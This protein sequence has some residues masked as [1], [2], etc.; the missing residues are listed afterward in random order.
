LSQAYKSPE[1]KIKRAF[2]K[3]GDLG[4]VAEE[5]TVP[6]TGRLTIAQVFHY[7]EGIAHTSGKGS[8]Q[9]KVDC[10]VQLLSKVS[11]AEAKY[12]VRT[13]LGTHRIG[14]GDMTFLRALAKAFTGKKHDKEVLESA[15]NVLSDLG[16]V[17][18]RLADKGI[19][20]LARVKPSP[21]I[22]VRMMLASRVKGL[23][24][25]PLHFKDG[26]F[27]EY[28]YDGERLQVHKDRQGRVHAFSRRLENITHQYPEI[29]EQASATLKATE[30]IVEGEA[31]CVDPKTGKLRPFQVLMQRKRKH[32]IERYRSQTPA[33]LFL[34]DMLYLDG[35][36][37]LRLPL[38]KRKKLLTDHLTASRGFTVG[39]FI[40]TA[41]MA[42]VESYFREAI[43]KGAEG[44]V[45]KDS[46]GPYQA[47]HR[48]WYWIKFK[49]EY[50]RELADTFDVVI[51]GALYGRGRRAGSYGS[52]LVASFDPKTNKYYSF[53]KVGAGFTDAVLRSLP[54][55]L[56]PCIIPE[57]DHLVVTEMPA[58]VWFEP[59]RVIEISGADLT[60][61]PVHTVANDKLKKGGL[62]LRFPKFLR[63][64]D[65][66]T[67]EQTTSV[68]E[69]W[70]MYKAARS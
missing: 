39:K 62:A 57:K 65:D 41:E 33:T 27:V 12:V 21:G 63:W 45:I 56:K 8:Q 64:R 52:V 5:L 24:E 67:A 46:K 55:V 70:D 59:V 44:V 25:V 6:R 19:G 2:S 48:G 23:D 17:A 68:G 69:I 29:I 9:A 36:D 3:S 53:T 15:Y 13:I 61:S 28:K 10:L 18:F 58:D 7:L 51:V 37:L 4:I 38:S 20:A 43:S 34:F 1:E 30:A 32:D 40:E 49:K 26:M 35:K 31:V 66:K 16:E 22:P 47:G 54:K 42:D 50:Q 60:I 14:V 11:P